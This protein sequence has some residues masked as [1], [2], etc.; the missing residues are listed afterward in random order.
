MGH[1]IGPKARI[2]RRLGLDVYDSSGATR[3]SRRR[4]NPPGMHGARR[5]RPTDYGRA[6]V[7]KQK[8]RHYYGLS[9]RQL[10]RFFDLAQ[11][12]TG[13]TGENLL[14]ICERR[15]D[16]I[17]WRAGL[18]R[19]R[20]QA[21][22][23]A[24]HSH[25]LVNGRRADVPSTILRA[26]DVIQVRPRENL[27][28]LYSSRVEE[29]DRPAADFLAIDPKE[30]TVKVVRLPEIDDVSLPVNINLVVELLSR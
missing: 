1:Y 19:T 27:Q 24:T 6:L 30:L 13:N 5:R 18:A 11:K 20:A 23:A 21:R 26:G 14:K 9:Q 15:L 4:T 3:A 10:M 29:N 8:I 25:V 28:K 7:E 12:M 17:I 22:Q 2:N 16:N